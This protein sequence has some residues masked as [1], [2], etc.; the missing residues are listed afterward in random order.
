[1]VSG[2][3]GGKALQEGM[4][5]TLVIILLTYRAS[6]DQ[7]KIKIK[8]VASFTLPAIEHISKLISG[9]DILASQLSCPR[10]L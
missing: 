8:A 6:A 3:S 4:L 1:M 7:V 10:A 2:S 5:W 9:H